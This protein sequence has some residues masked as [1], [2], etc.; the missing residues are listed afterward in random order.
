MNI[1]RTTLA[2][3]VSLALLGFAAAA[4][5]QQRDDAETLDAR[6]RVSVA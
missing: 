6:A 4:Q 3:A 5:A 2:T 1:Q